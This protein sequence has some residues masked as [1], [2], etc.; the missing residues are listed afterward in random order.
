MSLLTILPTLAA[1]RGGISLIGILI[2]ILVVGGFAYLIRISP[3]DPLWKNIAYVVL[4]IFVIVWLLRLA[5]GS[6]F[7]MTI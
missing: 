5:Q 6:G 1:A 4:A 7:D 2:I 3:L